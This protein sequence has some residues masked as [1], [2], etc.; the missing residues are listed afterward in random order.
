MTGDSAFER[1]VS[2]TETEFAA[3]LRAACPGEVRGGPREFT[4]MSRGA[5]LEI[6]IE[7]TAPRRIA[8]IVLPRLI[9]RY[10]FTRGTTEAQSV[11]LAHLDRA[12]QRGGG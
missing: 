11:L 10:R 3:S 12:M 1:D 4:V 7:P 6:A 9:A 8:S 2:A 5:V